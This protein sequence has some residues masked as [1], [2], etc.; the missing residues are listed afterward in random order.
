MWQQQSVQS[1][2][3]MSFQ[4]SRNQS[5]GGGNS[6]GR[7]GSRNFRG[8]GGRQGGGRQTYDSGRGS[9]NPNVVMG[10]VDQE[11][12]LYDICKYHLRDGV[13]RFNEACRHIHGLAEILF[14]IKA[15]ESPIKSM[16]FLNSDSPRLVTGSMDCSLKVRI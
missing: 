6:G 11:T 13:C 1:N 9:G 15:H 8:R 10:S 16:G 7:R 2:G 5:F 3:S 12:P 4:G 14:S